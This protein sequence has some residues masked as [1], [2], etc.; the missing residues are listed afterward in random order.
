M[1]DF[2][3]P[4]RDRTCAPAVEVQSPNH[5]TSREVPVLKIFNPGPGIAIMI[6]LGKLVQSFSHSV[7][8][9]LN[10]LPA[11]RH[12]AVLGKV[13]QCSEWAGTVPLESKCCGSNYSPA[14]H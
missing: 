8:S 11:P 13:R 7:C 9:E 4:T 6:P 10:K 3:S 14:A 1:G 12:L 5:W 2:G